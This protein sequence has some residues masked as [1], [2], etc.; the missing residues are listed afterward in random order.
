MCA[1]GILAAGL[2]AVSSAKSTNRGKA[3]DFG[4]NVIILDPTM[5]QAEIQS[6]IDAIAQEQKLAQ[7]GQG[8]YAIFLKPGT[9][10]LDAKIAFYTQLAGLGLSPDDVT[11]HGHVQSLAMAG[12]WSVLVSFWRSAENMCVIP[13]DGADHWAVSQAAPY[14]RMHVRGNLFLHDNGPG[15]G[16]FIADSEIEGAVDANWQQQWF[17]RNSSIRG[18]HGGLWNMVFVGVDGAPPATPENVD[19]SKVAIP[20]SPVLTD[21]PETPV[22]AEKPFLYVDKAGAFK[23]FVPSLKSNSQSISWA[24]GPPAGKSLSMSRFF[25]A[26][27]TMSA[28]EINSELSR[29][30]SLV[31]TPGI[32]QVAEPIRITHPETI[33]MGL[34]LATILPENGAIA[35]TVA[36]VGGVK[37][38]GILFD[39]G[40]VNSPILLEVGPEGSSKNHAAD[41]IFLYDIFARIG[42]AGAAGA[43]QSVVVNSHNVVGDDLWLWRAD[44]GKDVGWD[45]N[46]AA[47][48]LVVNGNDVT[49]YGLFVEHYQQYQVLWNGERGRTYFFQNEIPYDPPSQAAYRA[50]K[51]PGWSSYKVAANVKQHEAWGMGSYI[52]E[53]KHPEIVLAH[54]FETPDSSRIEFRNLITFSLGPGKGTIEHVINDYG[55]IAHQAKF[56][57]PGSL[58]TAYPPK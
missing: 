32:Y 10:T 26:K 51:T 17:T 41:P 29:G 46:P 22:I 36:D 35:M 40:A 53:P 49:M 9:Y 30:K 15:S 39:A 37:I 6:R 3:P 28:A 25:L 58:V 34:G 56:T 45:T 14:R 48:G 12:P 54:S 50:G 20:G 27:P 44:H 33:V 43:A 21:I 4:P 55:P 5:P 1:L 19:P 8:R 7:F 42:G 52:Y 31:L 16:G 47:N 23:V 13:P 38:S 57:D 24:N 2:P 11:I 18:W